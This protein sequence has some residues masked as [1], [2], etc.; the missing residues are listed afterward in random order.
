MN[1]DSVSPK[2]LISLLLDL[3]SI[4]HRILFRSWIFVENT[5]HQRPPATSHMDHNKSADQPPVG[6]VTRL[7]LSA[8]SPCQPQY[9]LIK[10]LYGIIV[11]NCSLN[12]CLHLLHRCTVDTSRN[13]FETLVFWFLIPWRGIMVGFYAM[14]F[15]VRGKPGA[16]PVLRWLNV[17][18][19]VPGV[20]CAHKPTVLLER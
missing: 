7:P 15:V 13:N 11:N 6:R 16:Y 3:V 4:Y 17:D 18:N 8:P 1:Q 19:A 14:I 9:L 2:F 12:H 5:A 10:T 20:I